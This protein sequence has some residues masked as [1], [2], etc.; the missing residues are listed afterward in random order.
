VSR[1]E[2]N[3]NVAGWAFFAC[4]VII[5]IVVA[6]RIWFANVKEEEPARQTEASM[7]EDYNRCVAEAP[8]GFTCVMVPMMVSE[9]YL[10]NM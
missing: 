9:Q 1:E 4:I 2:E 8:K 3:T 10:E 6:S 7:Q 5:A